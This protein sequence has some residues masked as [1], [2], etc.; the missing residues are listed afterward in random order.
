MTDATLAVG[1]LVG[2]RRWPYHAAHPDCWGKPW[3]GTVLAQ[4]DPR[5][6]QGTLAFPCRDG[7]QP[8]PDK[9]REHVAWCREQG[10]LRDSVP[11]LWDFGADG[12]RAMWERLDSVR[13]YA[14]DLAE[15][16]A[17]RTAALEAA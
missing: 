7:Q 17:E 10:L 11:V 6:W 3:A 1:T 9:V 12:P 14:A 2:A 4:D 15:W 13:P 16:E 8:D 5:A